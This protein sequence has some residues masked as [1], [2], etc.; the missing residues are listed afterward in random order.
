MSDL[1]SI[2]AGDTVLISGYGLCKA[3]VVKATKQHLITESGDKYRIKNGKKLGDYDAW[4][5]V[6]TIIPYDESRYQ[7]FLAKQREDK[8]RDD[9]RRF[10]WVGVDT[11]TLE[12]IHA[13]VFPKKDG[14]A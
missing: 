12:S 3:T 8:M 6:P 14:A 1:T 5:T 4:S 13:M 10:N 9:L 11:S 7:R 2:K